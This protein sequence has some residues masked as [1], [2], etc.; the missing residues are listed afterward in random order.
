M[1]PRGLCRPLD[2]KQGFPTNNLAACRAAGSAKTGSA[3]Q[4]GQGRAG[5]AGQGRAVGRAEGRAKGKGKGR[6]G[7]QGRAEAGRGRAG[8]G[9]AGQFQKDVKVSVLEVHVSRRVCFFSFLARRSE[10][11]QAGKG[12]R[13]PDV[14][15]EASGVTIDSDASTVLLGFPVEP[16]LG[17]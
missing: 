4:G 5:R 13:D 14:G 15:I 8:Q 2:E 3:G 12:C 17:C 11:F 7:Q 1:G 16:G 10:W 9:R 6:A